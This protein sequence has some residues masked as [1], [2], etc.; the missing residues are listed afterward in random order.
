MHK[1]G[2]PR[3]HNPLVSSNKNG[4]VPVSFSVADSNQTLDLMKA[5]TDM[6][7]EICGRH[8]GASSENGF[9]VGKGGQ[10]WQGS[11]KSWICEV[12][13]SRADMMLGD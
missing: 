8:F 7:E 4:G 9:I 10:D 2:S 3:E 5:T 11:N 13:F 6:K 1:V 12:P